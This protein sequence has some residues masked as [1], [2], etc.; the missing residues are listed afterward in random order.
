MPRSTYYYK[1][2]K[3][4]RSDLIEKIE[5][6]VVE[7]TGYGY[8]RV[9]KALHRQGIRVNHKVIRPLMK[10]RGLSCRQKRGFVIHTTDS[11]H[12]YPVYPNLLKDLVLERLNQVWVSDITYVRIRRGFA[13]LAAI[14]DALSRKVVGWAVG[15]MITRMLTIEALKRAIE[16]RKPPEG[17][18]HHSD[19]GVQYAA[20]EYVDVLKENKFQ[21]SMS[22][23]GNP[24]DNA[25]AE[26]F[27]KTYKYEEVYLTEYETFEDVVLN[28]ERFIEDI[29]NAKRLHSSIGYV[30]PNE[31]EANWRA[32]QPGS[33]LKV[34]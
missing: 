28:A 16:N 12:P 27:M 6:I 31:F 7:N 1:T 20:H 11:N 23:K 25:K 5:S 3:Q 30:P 15:R 26:S 13:Y 17:C 24:Y 19:R 29:Y 33:N 10:E 4:N 9:T 18:I 14:L 32:N 22:A 21:I 2:Q 34:A 8:R